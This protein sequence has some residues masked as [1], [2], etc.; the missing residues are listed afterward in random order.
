MRRAHDV[1]GLEAGPIDRTPH[2][3]E[4]WEWRIRM[5]LRHCTRANPPVFVVD[6]LRRAVEDLGAE[7]YQQLTYFERWTAAIAELL[8]RHGVIT[9]AELGSE[10][11]ALK[12]QDA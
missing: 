6:E 10:M 3:V 9:V 7:E 11:A 8:L 1:G 2:P 5:I 4:P 12:E